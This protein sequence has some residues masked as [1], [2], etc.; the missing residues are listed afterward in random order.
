MKLSFNNKMYII[1]IAFILITLSIIKLFINKNKAL[2]IYNKLSEIDNY[3]NYYSSVEHYENR[4]EGFKEG[5]PGILSPNEI[6]RK[7][8]NAFSVKGIKD[9]FDKPVNDIKDAIMKPINEIIDIVKSIDDAFKSIPERAKMFRHAFENVGE[10]IKLEFINIGESLDIGFKDIFSFIRAAGDCGVKYVTNL[11]SCMIWY[12]LD[13]IGTTIYNIFVVLPVFIVKFITGFNLQ[14]YVDLV[15][16]Y[17]DILDSYFKYFTCGDSFLHFPPWVIKLCY[18]C[19]LE[20]EIKKIDRDWNETIPKL[21]NEPAG[22]F[23]FAGKQFKNVFR[24][25][26]DGSLFGRAP[27]TK[28]EPIDD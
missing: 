19:D 20:R 4:I 17:I 25:K 15:H 23:D 11:R 10:G 6:N 7:L 22:V 27:R 28:Y 13:L 9:T 12:I 14:P 1:I 24:K 18:S 16:K 2:L 21:L 5:M 3:D 8:K 26:M